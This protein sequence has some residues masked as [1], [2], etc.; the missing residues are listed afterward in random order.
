MPGS[1][2]GADLPDQAAEQRFG[3]LHASVRKVAPHHLADSQH[4]RGAL[5]FVASCARG[6]PSGARPAGVVTTQKQD[7]PSTVFDQV[8]QRA[9]G[10]GGHVARMSCDCHYVAIHYPFPSKATVAGPDESQES[11]PMGE[12]AVS[13]AMRAVSTPRGIDMRGNKHSSMTPAAP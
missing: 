10:V 4:S 13:P 6:L 9:P 3:R 12:P 8:P 2:P 1:K 5:G 7:H 11:C